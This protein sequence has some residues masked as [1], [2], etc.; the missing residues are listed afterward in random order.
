MASSSQE[1]G[2]FYKDVGCTGIFYPNVLEAVK[3]YI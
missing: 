2:G 1:D 3:V